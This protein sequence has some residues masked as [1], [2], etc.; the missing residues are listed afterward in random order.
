MRK[1][2]ATLAEIFVEIADRMKPEAITSEV[3]YSF[4]AAIRKRGAKPAFKGYQGGAK[5][6]FPASTCISIDSEV[7]HGIPSKRRLLTGQLVGLDS[8][9]ELDGWFSD[10]AAS[11]MIGPVND[12]KRRLWKT[13]QEALYKGIEEARP[14]NRLNDIAGAIQ[15][16]I[17]KWFFHHPRF[18]G[19]R[20]RYFASR[21]T[22]RP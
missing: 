4:E 21:R 3:D 11:F 10:M 16:H 7:V 18:G 8:G 5:Y 2:G 17:E 15:D 9:L 12:V 1:A 19:A 14:G 22:C 13:T 6:P 20:H